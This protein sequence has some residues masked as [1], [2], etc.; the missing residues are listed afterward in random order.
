MEERIKMTLRKGASRSAGGLNNVDIISILKVEGIPHPP[1]TKRAELIKLLA[2]TRARKER[3][4]GEEGEGK[5]GTPGTTGKQMRESTERVFPLLYAAGYQSYH[6]VNP[7][8][9]PSEAGYFAFTHTAG[10]TENVIVD[11]S[12]LNKVEPASITDF[13]SANDQG[14]TTFTIANIPDHSLFGWNYN[15]GAW[16]YRVESRSPT[17][18]GGTTRY[19]YVKIRINAELFSSHALDFIKSQ[20]IRHD[21]DQYRLIEQTNYEALIAAMTLKGAL[22]QHG[23]NVAT[24]ES[25]TAGML[26]KTLVDIPGNGAVVYGG[27]AVYDTDAKRKFLG[28]RTEGVYSH[29]TAHQ[30]A[31]GTLQNSRALM[32]IAVTGNAMTLPN[33]TEHM[34]HV[35]FGIGLRIPRGQDPYTIVTFKRSFCDGVSKL[36]AD[37]ALLH[38]RPGNPAPF[39]MTSLLADYIRMKTVKTACELAKQV[40]DDNVANLSKM[41]LPT[42][43]WDEYCKPSWIINKWNKK[44]YPSAVDCAAYS[45][46]D[47]TTPGPSGTPH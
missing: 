9:D 41:S 27:F 42:E 24:A 47:Y 3:A 43:A 26:V 20:L 44:Q 34:G 5:P 45:A 16:V 36:C 8:D 32:S 14:H 18:V 22:A 31:V 28:V 29:K 46:T 17:S 15:L 37:W 25:L 1:A 7:Q 12:S 21:L 38:A 13:R 40:I 6:W 11:A 35:Y 2:T 30:M 19:K 10:H 33:D 4:G 39:Q 23:L